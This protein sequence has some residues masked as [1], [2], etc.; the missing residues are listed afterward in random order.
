MF[1]VTFQNVTQ[2]ILVSCLTMENLGLKFY[3]F[4]YLFSQQHAVNKKEY[5]S[6]DSS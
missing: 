3:I 6:L 2:A 4:I 1:I 5:A